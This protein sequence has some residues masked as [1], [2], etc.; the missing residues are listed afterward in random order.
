MNK[1]K[2]IYTIFII[3]GLL[4]GLT[5][6]GDILVENKIIIILC[7]FY[8]TFVVSIFNK[9]INGEY[10]KENFYYETYLNLLIDALNKSHIY[11][12]QIKYLKKDMENLQPTLKHIKTI[13]LYLNKIEPPPIYKDLHENIVLNLKDYLEEFDM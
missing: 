12:R 13:Y 9:D 5:L 3:I 11:M 7:L 10:E 2:T 8:I 6:L 4:M 1:N